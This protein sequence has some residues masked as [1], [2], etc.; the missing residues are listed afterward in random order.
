MDPVLLTCIPL[1]LDAEA[2]IRKYRL[3]PGS[4]RAERVRR[5]AEEA[6]DQG[7]PKAMFL[8]C[9]I[10]ARS[11]DNV[12]IGGETFRSRVLAVN[13]EKVHRVFPFAATCGRELESWSRSLNGSLETFW[14]AD[15][16]GIALGAALHALVARMRETHCPGGLSMMNPGSLEDWPLSEQVPL[17]RVLRDP[18][19]SV[20][21]VKLLES[22][23][24][25]PGMTVSGIWFPSEARFENCMLCPREACVGRRA[26]H[27][28]D[29]YD[30][31]VR[32]R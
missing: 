10:D 4:A 18:V 19:Q 11:E 32:K 27:D 16:Q 17:F 1:R 3:E 26:P 28:P 7:R 6:A 5:L 24:M 20:L 14:A 25:D 9:G 31:M 15:I 13:L 22:L 21:G 2:L 30:R 12:V 8:D 23:R 29:L